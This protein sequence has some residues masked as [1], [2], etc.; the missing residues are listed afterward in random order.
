MLLSS[1]SLRSQRDFSSL[2]TSSCELSSVLLYQRLRW[3]LVLPNLVWGCALESA[4]ATSQRIEQVGAALTQAEALPSHPEIAQGSFSRA[5]EP[6]SADA[7]S[8]KNRGVEMPVRPAT[9]RPT[10]SWRSGLQPSF[11]EFSVSQGSWKL[12]ACSGLSSASQKLLLWRATSFSRWLA[13]VLQWN[14]SVTL[15]RAEFMSLPSMGARRRGMAHGLEKTVLPFW[16]TQET[17]LARTPALGRTFS[18]CVGLGTKWYTHQ[19]VVSV[20]K[21][22]CSWMG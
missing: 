14:A 7:Q 17:V 16:P 13:P 18:R 11:L 9:P 21:S 10:P 15:K 12:I 2:M 20:R 3:P 5:G 19:D 22:A 8:R 4:K 6:Q 1:L